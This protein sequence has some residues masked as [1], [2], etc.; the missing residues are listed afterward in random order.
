MCTA[1]VQYSKELRAQAKE[2]GHGLFCF[3]VPGIRVVGAPMT[4]ADLNEAIDMVIAFL[5]KRDAANKK[6]KPKG[7][8]RGNHK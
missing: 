4:R 7:A 8:K 1:K 3:E 5:K 2:R 6:L